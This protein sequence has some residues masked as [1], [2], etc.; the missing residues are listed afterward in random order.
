MQP[1]ADKAYLLGLRAAQ[2]EDDLSGIEWATV[3]LL[4]QAMTDKQAEVKRI[5][6]RA[7]GACSND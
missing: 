7:A 3:G 4:S 5:A 1:L 2:R 6:F